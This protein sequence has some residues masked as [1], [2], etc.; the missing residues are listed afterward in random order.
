MYT[1]NLKLKDNEVPAKINKETGEI[2][3]VRNE[4]KSLELTREVFSSKTLF[5]KTYEDVDRFLIKKLSDAEYKVVMMMALMADA[6]T[7]SLKPLD[8]STSMRT[9][10]EYFNVDRRRIRAILDKLFSLGVYAKFKIAEVDNPY[11]N[12]WILNPYISFKGRVIESDI[13]K[14]F[15]NTIIA[16]HHFEEMSKLIT[17]VVD[18]K[19][20][21][22]IDS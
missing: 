1:R 9:L 5:R 4:F 13:M 10:E 20:T 16:R 11:K 7:N 8:D 6:G 17:G 14:L 22:L 19:G 21:K 3:E 18:K 15:N 12:Y 2:V